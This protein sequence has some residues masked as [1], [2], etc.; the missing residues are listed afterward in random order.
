MGTGD[1]KLAMLESLHS[2]LMT[3]PWPQRWILFLLSLPGL[4]ILP[5]PYGRMLLGCNGMQ[6]LDDWL[7]AQTRVSG[8]SCPLVIRNIDR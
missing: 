5:L 4:H 6:L 7:D 1:L 8:P 3:L 2:A